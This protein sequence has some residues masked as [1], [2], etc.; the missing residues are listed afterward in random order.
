MDIRDS[1][2]RGKPFLPKGVAFPRNKLGEKMVLLVQINFEQVPDLEPFPQS[3]I[4]QIFVTSNV[5]QEHVWGK[6]N[7][8]SGDPWVPLEYF[9]HLQKQDYFKV[10]YFS[11]EACQQE[12]QPIGDEELL[13]DILPIMSP[14]KLE[15]EIGEEYCGVEDYRFWDYLRV[16]PEEFFAK[17]GNEEWDDLD[18]FF[19]FLASEDLAKLGG[20]GRFTCG[21]PRTE[22]KARN[23]W[24]VLLNI[25]SGPV[26]REEILW[27]DNGVG[28]FFIREPDLKNLN[29]SAVAYYWDNH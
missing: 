2:F 5:N 3:G 4:L 8:Y 10:Q 29:F 28:T 21:D 20:Y 7:Y 24:M 26:G 12:S 17:H 13:D 19:R 25:E 9:E 1:K 16:S 6:N 27:G 23:E 18:N 11:A 14:M 15:F 22:L